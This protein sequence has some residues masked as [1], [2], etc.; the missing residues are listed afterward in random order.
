[1]DL[2]V[3]C[4]LCC[5]CEREGERGGEGGREGV[6]AVLSRESERDVDEKKY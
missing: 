1:M 2:V 3:L 5:A 6:R 4:T